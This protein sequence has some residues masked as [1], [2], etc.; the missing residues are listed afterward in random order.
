[1]DG[2]GR[3][4]LMAAGMF[5]QTGWTLVLGFTVSALLQSVVS[6][7]QMRRALGRDGAR[8]IALASL[9]GAASSSCSYASAAIMRTLFK[10]GA[11]LTTSLAFLFASTNL[12]L[13]LGII[14]YLLLGWP[15]M[16]GEWIGG[17]V[18]IAVMSVI[19]RLT[20]PKR[21]AEEA[22]NHEETS[23]GHQHM[24]MTV[25]GS[26]LREKLANPET[27]IRIAQNF[28]MEWSMLWKDLAIGFLVGGLLSAFVPDA[29]WKALFLTDASPWLKVPLNA[30]LGPLIA[31][32]TFVCSIGNVPLAAV[33]WGGGASFG[34]VL[35][36]LYADLIVLP[37]L[38][39][40]RRYFGW[41]MAAY[42]G[43]V[44]Y[45]TMVIAALVM[46]LAFNGLGWVPDHAG[47]VRAHLTRF[48]LNYTFWL[49]L[50]FGALAAYW[51]WL[52]RKHPMQHGH[53]DHGS[54]EGRHAHH[55]S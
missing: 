14:L 39:A 8:E 13:E 47:D 37:L 31:V 1:M 35:A 3:A 22:R 50:G 15:F 49:N 21:L 48:A 24:S 17:L 23:A 41:R 46:D 40:Y 26:T 16:A 29:A 10:K 11:A 44:F 9:A 55:H 43:G 36:F 42:I 5:W 30:L 4:L 6:T 32:L 19:V 25:E 34:G 18:L 53:G 28:A 7:E 27:R 33:L 20:Y 52:A 54:G 2:L 12:V 45:V 38:D 51:F